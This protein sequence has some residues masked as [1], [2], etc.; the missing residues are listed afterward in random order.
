MTRLAHDT[1]EPLEQDQRNKAGAIAAIQQ[2]TVISEE[3]ERRE[4]ERVHLFNQ[5]LNQQTRVAIEH[6]VKSRLPDIVRKVIQ[7]QSQKEKAGQSQKQEKET[8]L[9]KIVNPIPHYP[10]QRMGQY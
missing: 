2:Q 9:P 7:E 6:F 8:I 3:R 5:K 1:Q 4:W 10:P